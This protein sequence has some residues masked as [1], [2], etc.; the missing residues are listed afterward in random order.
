MEIEIEIGHKRVYKETIVIFLL[1]L[2]VILASLIRKKIINIIV[3]IIV[4]V[5]V[6]GVRLKGM[7]S[8]KLIITVFSKN[9]SR[10]LILG[11]A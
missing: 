4:I 8:L 9:Q 2:K 10:R 6:G 3:I 5:S 11:K 1:M 7:V